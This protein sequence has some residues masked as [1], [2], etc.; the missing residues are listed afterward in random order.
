MPEFYWKILT[1]LQ[2]FALSHKCG[3]GHLESFILSPNLC[4]FF[5]ITEWFLAT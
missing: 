1:I 5:D 4:K 3:T 2:E